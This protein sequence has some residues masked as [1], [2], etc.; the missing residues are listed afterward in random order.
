[1]AAVLEGVLEAKPAPSLVKAVH[2]A[3]Q[4]TPF[5]VEELAA[6]LLVSGAL[7]AGAHGPE[8]DRASAIPVPDTVRDAVLIRASELSDA[9]EMRRG[10]GGR[11]GDVRPRPRGIA[12]KPEGVAE[13]LDH[14]WPSS[15]TSAP[16]ASATRLTREALYADVPWMRAARA[17]P[18]DRGG[19]RGA[20]RAAAARSP[21]LARR[22]RR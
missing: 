3:T 15:R 11:G 19:A 5:F 4:G 7:K 9:G 14:G 22:A 20:R 8:L 10:R 17:A 16:R 2:D 1:V 6:A 21:A 12:V 13:L 18:R